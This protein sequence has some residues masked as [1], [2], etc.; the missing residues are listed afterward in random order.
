MKGYVLKDY[1]L[2]SDLVLQR[3]SITG[4]Y[5]VSS[6]TPKLTTALGSER[7]FVHIAVASSPINGELRPYDYP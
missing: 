3:R 7:E 5:V 1:K 4:P 2:V 6:P